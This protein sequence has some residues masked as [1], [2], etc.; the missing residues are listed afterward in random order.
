MLLNYAV[1][2]AKNKKC[3]VIELTSN[4]TREN[5][6]RFYEKNGFKKTSF[7]FKMNLNY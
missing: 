2:L 6:H 3:D 7:K 5:A 1:Q 4:F